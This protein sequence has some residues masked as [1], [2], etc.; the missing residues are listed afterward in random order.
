MTISKE[1]LEQ[2]WGRITD[3]DVK[4]VENALRKMLAL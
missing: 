1:R 4:R 2:R 3:D